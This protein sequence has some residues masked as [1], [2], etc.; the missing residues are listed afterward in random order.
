MKCEKKMKLLYQYDVY[1]SE[2]RTPY[3]EYVKDV[4]SDADGV[5]RTPNAI[6]DLLNLAFRANELAEERLWLIGF[7]A[8]HHCVGLF[9]VSHGSANRSVASSASILKRALLIGAI[10]I[11]VAHNHPSGVVTPSDEDIA[12]T[13]QLH[14][15]ARLC[16]I[17]LNDHIIIGAGSN[18]YYSMLEHDMID[19]DKCEEIYQKMCN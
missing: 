16:D 4:R 15:A 9:E 18:A 1:L 3:L 2:N 10:S 7:D 11:I 17:V 5:Y 13:K 14:I 6:L 8:Q 12:F 19:H